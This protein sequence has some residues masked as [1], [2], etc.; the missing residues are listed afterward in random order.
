MLDDCDTVGGSLLY[1]S[2]SRCPEKYFRKA[3]I[4]SALPR[5]YLKSAFQLATIDILVVHL[6][7]EGSRDV[8]VLISLLIC[9]AFSSLTG[10]QPHVQFQSSPYLYG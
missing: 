6:F 5:K 2:R 1:W 10:F 9:F 4:C 3:H 8:S 7:I